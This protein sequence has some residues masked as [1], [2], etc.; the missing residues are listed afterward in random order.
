MKRGDDEGIGEGAWAGVA[1]E[2]VKKDEV[3]SDGGESPDDEA[4]AVDGERGAGHAESAVP[5]ND[6][7]DDFGDDFGGDGIGEL[8]DGS[9]AGGREMANVDGARGNELARW[10]A[11]RSRWSGFQFLRG[12]GTP[13]PGFERGESLV[14]AG[15]VGHR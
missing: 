6:A 4:E 15:L 10:D 14:E 12:L 3:R 8:A 5:S 11:G 9:A 1:G 13:G 2:R 7:E